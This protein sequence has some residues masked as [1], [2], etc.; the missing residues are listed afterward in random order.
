MGLDMYLKRAKFVDGEWTPSG[1]GEL[2]YWR[3]ANMIR[4]WIVDHTNYPENGDCLFHELSREQIEALLSDCKK[5]YEAQDDKLSAEI[6][7]TNSGYYFGN[8]EYDEYYYEDIRYTIEKL[9]E[10][11]EDWDEITE[12]NWKVCYYEWW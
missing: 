1:I 4:Q 8:T 3:K 12:N 2:V 10:L 5:V 9:E 7:P 11:L 6:I